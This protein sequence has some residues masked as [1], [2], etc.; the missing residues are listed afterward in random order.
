[1]RT[2]TEFEQAFKEI[3]G[4]RTLH[5]SAWTVQFKVDRISFSKI[6]QLRAIPIVKDVVFMPQAVTVV[7]QY[8]TF[9]VDIT[10]SKV[11]LPT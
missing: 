2:R 9:L 10:F 11:L 3:F 6:E 1:M 7:P 8:P 4:K 5:W